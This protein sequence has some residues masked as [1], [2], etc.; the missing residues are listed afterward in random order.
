MFFQIFFLH[1]S[2]FIISFGTIAQPSDD[3]DNPLS[4]IEL[5]SSECRESVENDEIGTIWFCPSLDFR[6]IFSS[7]LFPVIRDGGRRGIVGQRGK[8]G[9]KE[10]EK[11]KERR[12]RRRGKGQEKIRRR[13][14]GEGDSRDAFVG[15]SLGLILLIT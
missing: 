2:D 4:G 6:V 3:F 12:R 1:F 8:I 9:G 5:D 10:K 13:P 7:F 15:H 14:L 11:E